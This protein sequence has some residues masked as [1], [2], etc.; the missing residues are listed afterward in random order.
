MNPYKKKVIL[1]LLPIAD[2]IFAPFVYLSA[3]LLKLV[4]QAR[5][6]RLPHCRQA[7][8]RVGVFPIRDHYYEPQIDNRKTRFPFSQE[9][10]LPGIDWNI[11]GQLNLLTSFTFAQEIAK[12]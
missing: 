7:L 2:V 11:N 9:R 1:R 6:D 12:L 5:V 3:W 4:R 8:W 10:A